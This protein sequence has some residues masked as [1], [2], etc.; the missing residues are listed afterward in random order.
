VFV[1]HQLLVNVGFSDAR[2]RLADLAH[3]GIL[4]TASRDAY[5]Q[6]VASL[7]QVGPLASVPTTS[8][9]DVRVRDSMIA[10][11]SAVL[12]VR[13]ETTGQDG[14]VF[15]ALDADITLASADDE[16]TV[17]KL[18]GAYRLPPQ[19]ADAGLDRAVLRRVATVTVH[20]FLV[21][22][23]EAIAD[24]TAAPQRGQAFGTNPGEPWPLADEQP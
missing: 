18:D 8:E 4:A 19:V 1:G 21:R 14:A 13:W 11:G 5:G 16:A 17:L 9:L 15:S 10:R 24:P 20:A 3:D 23:A 22:V 2:A 6:G 12:A 7:G